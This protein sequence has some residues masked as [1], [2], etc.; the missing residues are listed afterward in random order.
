MLKSW[1]QALLQ[2][3]CFSHIVKDLGQ[4]RSRR[5]RRWNGLVV[6]CFSPLVLTLDLAPHLTQAE[7]PKRLLIFI[8]TVNGRRTLPMVTAKDFRSWAV[9]ILTL[10]RSILEMGRTSEVCGIALHSLPRL[11]VLSFLLISC[12]SNRWRDTREV[13]TL[14][15]PSKINSFINQAAAGSHLAKLVPGQ[16]LR[17]C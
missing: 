12:N 14:R 4:T 6:A 9:S 1:P 5:M 13:S 15:L 8:G 7:E 10:C 11:L 16:T 17:V 2:T 3:F